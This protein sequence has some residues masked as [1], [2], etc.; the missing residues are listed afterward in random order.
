MELLRVPC[1]LL[2]LNVVHVDGFLV[3]RSVFRVVRGWQHSRVLLVL[4]PAEGVHSSYIDWLVQIGLRTPSSIGPCVS[5]RLICVKLPLVSEVIVVMSHDMA[6]QKLT[7][8]CL[9]IWHEFILGGGVALFVLCSGMVGCIS[10]QLPHS[11]L[12]RWFLLEYCCPSWL[13]LAKLAC[14]GGLLLSGCGVVVV[15]IKAVDSSS[16]LSK[17]LPFDLLFLGSA[18]HTT[19]PM[20]F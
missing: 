2:V 10:V 19:L 5:P 17:D 18:K 11:S 1:V 6:L 9:G 16:G 20:L 7:F 14:K 12:F 8:H 4:F 13:L 3:H 15:S